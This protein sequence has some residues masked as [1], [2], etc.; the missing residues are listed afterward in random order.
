[1][2]DWL[3]R[4]RGRFRDEKL[5]DRCLVHHGTAQDVSLKVCTLVLV[6]KESFGHF[7]SSQTLVD[8]RNSTCFLH[9]PGEDR[10]FISSSLSCRINL[11]MMSPDVFLQKRS[12]KS[13]NSWELELPRALSSKRRPGENN[14]GRGLDSSEVWGFLNEKARRR[15]PAAPLRGF[16]LVERYVVVSPQLP[17]PDVYS[18]PGRPTFSV[19]ARQAGTSSWRDNEQSSR[20]GDGF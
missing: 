1:M 8:Q 11:H 6:C 16:H 10:C 13:P 12:R 5:E 15:T 9:V 20:P 4:R 2:K 7:G 17:A 14:S 19:S 3:T 18:T